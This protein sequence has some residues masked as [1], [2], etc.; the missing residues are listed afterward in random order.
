MPREFWRLL[1]QRHKNRLGDILGGMRLAGHAERGGI[2]QVNVP[3]H[4]FG[5]G[6]IGMVF[7]VIA[8]QLLVAQIVHS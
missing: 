5:K 7:R 1:R 8:Q 3:L 6:G 2:N 4:Q